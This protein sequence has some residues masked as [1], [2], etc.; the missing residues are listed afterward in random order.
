MCTLFLQELPENDM[1]GMVKTWWCQV[2][3]LMSRS[4]DQIF[5]QG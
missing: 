2:Q 3:F 5:G 1:R 4:S